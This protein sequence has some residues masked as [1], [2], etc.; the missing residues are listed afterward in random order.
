MW[1]IRPIGILG[2]RDELKTCPNILQQLVT[3][4]IGYVVSVKIAHK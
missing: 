2:E 3:W 1:K 4:S